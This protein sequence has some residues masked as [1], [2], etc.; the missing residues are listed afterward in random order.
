MNLKPKCAV[1][2]KE[3]AEKYRQVLMIGPQGYRRY[4]LCEGCAGKAERKNLT[5]SPFPKG[6]G[7]A[8]R[9]AGV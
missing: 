4:A 5:P 3:L 6:K 1:C 9:K 2:K 7:S 8:V